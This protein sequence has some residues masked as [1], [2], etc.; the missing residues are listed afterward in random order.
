LIGHSD[1]ELVRDATDLIRLI[2]DHVALRPRGR[3]HVGLC[4]FHDDKNPSF[5]VVTHKGNAFYKCHACGAGG[6]AFDFVMNYHRMDFGE[7]LRF[8]ADRAGVTLRPR[9]QESDTGD[10]APSRRSDLRKAN[11]FAA[12]FFQRILTDES[13]GAAARQVIRTRGISD[14][15][16]QAFMLGAAPDSWDG[17]LN[18]IRKQSLD[19]RL[20]VTAGLLKPRK[21]GAAGNYDAFRNRLIFPICDELGQPIAFGARKI[22]PED[23]PKYLN[24]AESPLFSKS[25][26][27]YGLHLA[28]RQIIDKRCAIVTEGYTDVIACHQSGFRNVIATLGTA[29]T[30]EHAQILSRLCD[31]IVLLF[32]G[33]EAG[34]KAGGRG[35]EVLA[36]HFGLTAFFHEKVDVDVCMLPDQ[37]DPDE[38]LKQP[39][40][41]SR[42]AAL[43]EQSRDVLDFVFNRFRSQLDQSGGMSA[44]QKLTEAFLLQLSE[45][46]F[47]KVQGLRR[48]LILAR[49]AELLGVTP[50]QVDA[51]MPKARTVAPPQPQ[52]S[53]AMQPESGPESVESSESVSPA[54]RRAERDLLAMLIYQPELYSVRIATEEHRESTIDELIEPTHFED[55]LACDLA[56]VMFGKLQRGETVTVQSMLG[57]LVLPEAKSLASTLYFDGRRLCDSC[58]PGSSIEQ[59]LRSAVLSLLAHIQLRQ[60][61]QTVSDYRQCRDAPDKALRAVQSVLEQRRRQGHIASA[62]GRGV[63]S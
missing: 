1:I 3:E 36:S 17:L 10:S 21:E 9:R 22:D 25:R 50:A 59:T 23:E 28:K 34:Q 33:D 31:R 2:G 51:A 19:E 41:P 44:R 47:G 24:S 42:F 61:H 6:D 63:R 5:A 38:L 40:G 53:V 45:L 46:G 15:M 56:R 12:T 60:Y 37:L 14:E 18:R 54:R 48:S 52:S 7:A 58:P 27:L 13:V 55:A 8:L 57:E 39:D 43:L 16:V 29:L 49:L 26:T 20:F 35:F 62:L 11:A 4:P 32:D 30:R